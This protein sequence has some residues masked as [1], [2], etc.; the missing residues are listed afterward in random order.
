MNRSKIQP[1]STLHESDVLDNLENSIEMI[2]EG[3]SAKAEET[4][5]GNKA[6]APAAKPPAQEEISVFKFY[7]TLQGC[8]GILIKLA[9]FFCFINGLV[10]PLFA[11]AFGEVT[12]AYNPKN[13]DR[14]DDIML[15][16]FGK[17]AIVAAYMWITAYVYFSLFQ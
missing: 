6:E 15:D 13:K 4:K 5:K 17:L 16:M 11:L 9:F 14:V 2:M 12:D 8:D 1:S 3:G 10:Y 7:G